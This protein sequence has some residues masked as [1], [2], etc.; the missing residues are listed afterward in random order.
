MQV[1][2]GIGSPAAPFGRL[3]P[4]PLVR[5]SGMTKG[6]QVNMMMIYSIFKWIYRVDRSRQTQICISSDHSI[7]RA[8]LSMK[9]LPPAHR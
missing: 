8:A 4:G 9:W 6:N 5:P 3:G 7:P 1:D 2:L